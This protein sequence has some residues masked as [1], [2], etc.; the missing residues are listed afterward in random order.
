[1]VQSDKTFLKSVLKICRELNRE[2]QEGKNNETKALE[3]GGVAGSTV[4]DRLLGEASWGRE[5]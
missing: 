1:M 5:K 3:T 2:K 4:I